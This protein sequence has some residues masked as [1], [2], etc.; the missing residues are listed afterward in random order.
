MSG[1]K[2]SLAYKVLMAEQMAELLAQGSFTGAP[3]DLA[4][5]FIHLSTEAQLPGTLA[6]HFAGQ[7]DLHLAAVDLTALGDAVRW[8]VSRGGELFPHIYAALPLTAVVA[9]GPLRWGADGE[10]ELPRA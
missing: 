6:K 4:D 5:G 1:A 9:H 2:P 8:E 3:V 7:S 10:P